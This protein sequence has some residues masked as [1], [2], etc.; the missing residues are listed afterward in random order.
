MHSCGTL[1]NFRQATTKQPLWRAYPNLSST[2]ETVTPIRN[3]SGSWVRSDEDRAETFA[4]HLSLPAEPCH[5]F[6][7]PTTNPIWN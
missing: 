5:W 4:L 1:K 3:S 7:Y 2:I 6:S